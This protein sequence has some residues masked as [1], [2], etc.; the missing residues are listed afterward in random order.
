MRYVLR[1]DADQLQK[2][3]WYWN[4]NL[5]LKTSLAVGKYHSNEMT[6]ELKQFE[7]VFAQCEGLSYRIFKIAFDI[8]DE[9][10]A[11]EVAED[12]VLLEG[13]ELIGLL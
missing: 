2:I 8:E 1:S 3:G 10:D 6:E 4:N 7:A 9:S 5:S 13:S 12:I 11:L